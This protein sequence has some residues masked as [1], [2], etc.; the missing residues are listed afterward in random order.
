MTV[1]ATYRSNPA[2]L[3]IG[4]GQARAQH[5]VFPGEAS[6]LVSAQL[7]QTLVFALVLAVIAAAAHHVVYSAERA[8]YRAMLEFVGLGG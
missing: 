3:D 5:A 7:R 2:R 1:V 4:H 8:L 6:A